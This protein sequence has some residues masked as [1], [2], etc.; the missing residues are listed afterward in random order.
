VSRAERPPRLAARVLHWAAARLDIP[1]LTEDAAELFAARVRST[2]VRAAR[3]WYRRQALGSLV[4]A[5]RPG[6]AWLG[7]MSLDFRLGFR[8][9]VKYPGLTIVGGLAMAFAIWAGAVAFEAATRLFRPTL[10]LEEG[11]RVVAIRVLDAATGEEQNPRLDD[12]VRW[13]EVSRLVE[14]LGAFRDLDRNLIAADGR[15]ELVAVAEITASAFTMGRV[16]PLLGRPLVAADELPGA[17]P[18][19]VLG[20]D[21]WRR[22]FA[23]DPRVV[24]RSIRLGRSV[25]TVVGVMPAGFEFP[26]G[27]SVWVPLRAAAG[28]ALDSGPQVRVFGRLGDG[29]MLAEAQRELAALGALP[30]PAGRRDGEELRPRVMPYLSSVLQTAKLEPRVL[31]ALHFF[32]V[33]LVVLICGN[34]ALLMFARAAT[35]E[36]ELIT[37]SAL[38]ASRGRIV[39]QLFA[40][41]AALAFVASGVGL[42]AADLCVRWRFGMQAALGVVGQPPFWERSG[43]SPATLGYAGAL[44]LIASAV[45]GVVPGLKATRGLE[46]RLRRAAAGGAIRFGGIWTVIV[47]TQVAAMV[48]FP[49]IASI[50]RGQAEDIRSVDSGFDAEEFLQVQLALDSE[51]GAAA[52]GRGVD[53]AGSAAS[54]DG[55]AAR[56]EATARALE[57]R[58]E[59]EVDV[60]GV[61]FSDGPPLMTRAVRAIE[62]DP[63]G[64]FA[65]TSGGAVHVK[66]AAVAPDYLALLDAPVL[67]GRGFA[68]ADVAAGAPVVIVN[69]SFVERAL[70]G[71]NPIG[72]RIR[73][74]RASGQG[75]AGPPEPWFEIVGVVRD[76]GRPA[77]YEHGARAG[78]YHP[79]TEP[80]AVMTVHVRGEAHRFVP[81][82]RS[83]AAAVDPTLRLHAPITLAQINREDLYFVRLQFWLVTVVSAGAV[84][85]SLAGIYSVLSF[86]VSQR[87][88]EM[89]VRLALGGGA[90]P[91]AVTMIRRPLAL[92]GAGVLIGAVETALLV[93]AV[94]GVS[95][96]RMLGVAGYIVLMVGVCTLASLVPVRRALTIEP[97]EALRTDG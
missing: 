83:L 18:V 15:V 72:Q 11:D 3:R 50:L 60:V 69:Q 93:S 16:P 96:A 85:L 79:L 26:V 38:G 30:P 54:G 97:T 66:R 90:W 61:T 67:A 47:V 33:L 89:G 5:L 95:P 87:T 27:E 12:Y 58:L 88:R 65:D 52:E 91:V 36:T 57:R 70:A 75:T 62:V 46:A 2:G 68:H 94:K 19:A 4:R 21:V 42:V 63:A 9:L 35:R 59:S 25:H 84:L 6:A 74:V 17:A 20:R 86:T 49:P 80:P 8:M 92:V 1:E 45:A 31:L 29:V 40:E 56:I 51:T 32:A 41:A 23:S 71:R 37:R 7:G 82:L 28:D 77:G 34:V 10:P 53:R 55:S 44:A 14:D 81:R 73:Y 64:A 39:G 43:L 22:H 48:A 78:I 24:G 13:R 76:I